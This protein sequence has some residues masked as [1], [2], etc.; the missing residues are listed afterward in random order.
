MTAERKSPKD[1]ETYI[2]PLQKDMSMFYIFLLKHTRPTVLKWEQKS[3]GTRKSAEREAK[4]QWFYLIFLE[5]DKIIFWVLWG[6]TH[7]KV[8]FTCLSAGALTG[9]MLQQSS[10]IKKAELCLEER[11]VRQSDAVHDSYC[12]CVMPTSICV[13]AFVKANGLKGQ[14]RSKREMNEPGRYQ[15]HAGGLSWQQHSH[16]WKTARG[17]VFK[18]E[19]WWNQTHDS[20]SCDSPGP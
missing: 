9:L 7:S 18:S 12:V 8:L 17:W 2:N 16:P 1:T 13:C 6:R 11:A 3:R 10:L 19:L 20:L 15:G 5:R 4:L 14:Q